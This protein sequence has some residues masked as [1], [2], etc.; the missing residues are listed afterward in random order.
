MYRVCKPSQ[1]LNNLLIGFI[2]FT[3][4]GLPFERLVGFVYV[5]ICHG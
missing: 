3:I 5:R 4:H 1:W 2:W